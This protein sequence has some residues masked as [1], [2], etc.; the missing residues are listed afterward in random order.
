MSN[1]DV[2]R[3]A[4]GQNRVVI[5]LNDTHDVYESTL[6]KILA[7]P[8]DW[9]PLGYQAKEIAICGL[10]HIFIISESERQYKGSVIQDAKSGSPVTVPG[11]PINPSKLTVDLRGNVY[12]VD[13]NGGLW[14]Y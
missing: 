2:S 14:I 9:T 6:A 4:A 11:S 8:S 5:I 12:V 13:L 10:E 3:V 7:N 1:E